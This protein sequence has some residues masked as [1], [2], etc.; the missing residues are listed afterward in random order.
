MTFDPEHH[1]HDDDEN[2]LDDEGNVVRWVTQQPPA[3]PEWEFSWWDMAGVASTTIA[4]VLT[5]LGQGMN[6]LSREFYAAGQWS[7]KQRE[8][9]RRRTLIAEDIRSLEEGGGHG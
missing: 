6:I 9:F 7:R 3:P 2:C 4:G 1:D 5:T 8:F